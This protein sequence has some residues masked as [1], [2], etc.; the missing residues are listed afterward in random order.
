MHD[1]NPDQPTIAPPES[2]PLPQ[3]PSQDSSSISESTKTESPTPPAPANPAAI[4]PRAIPEPIT[5]P[6][7]PAIKPAPPPVKTE[8]ARLPRK[9]PPP[10]DPLS[11]FLN[12]NAEEEDGAPMSFIDHLMELRKRLWVCILACLIC[13]ALAIIFYDRVYGVLTGPI[14]WL[15]DRLAGPD[16]QYYR[17]HGILREGEPAILLATTGPLSNMLLIIWMGFWG[18]IVVASPIML[19]Q[20]WAFVAPGLKSNEKRAIMPVL[21]G[22]LGFF[23]GGVYICYRWMIPPTLWFFIT[24]DLSLRNR[25]VWT[26]ET[27]IDLLL[28]MMIISGFLCEIPLIVA[29]MAKMDVI[30]GSS[31]TK[32]W[33]GMIFGSILIGAIV[34]PG[35]DLASMGVFSGLMLGIYAVSI[36]MAYLFQQRQPKK[37]K[38]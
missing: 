9:Q 22:G 17:D 21:Y 31:L 27:T 5:P 7:P 34:A 28:W 15:N 4:V 23:L 35:N 32:H 25:I 30:R 2:A 26:S 36:I 10:K 16:G 33:R 12:K 8:S 20:V 24:L 1:S 37:K 38:P 13:V 14:Q 3:L 11:K 19:Y 29:A 18:G 6:A